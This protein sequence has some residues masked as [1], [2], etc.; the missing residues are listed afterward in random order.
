[1]ILG[2]ELVNLPPAAIR[3]ACGHLARVMETHVDLLLEQGP[4]EA[5]T[6]MAA[7]VRFFLPDY[8]PSFGEPAAQAAAD[9]QVARALHRAS[10]ADLAPFA[11][12]IVGAF[13]PESLYA[14]AEEVG[15][16]AGLLASGDLAAALQLVAARHGMGRGTG[17]PPLT[18]I[19]HIPVA[20]RLVDF[21]L[22]DDYEELVQALDAVS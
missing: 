8:R 21:A 9:E 10:R 14:D 17:P 2:A 7:I 1:V 6:L 3:Y 12:E 15:A 11:S 13:T 20:A 4:L 5:A 19:L 16:R 18:T 22:S